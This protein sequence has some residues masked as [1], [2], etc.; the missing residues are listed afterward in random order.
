MRHTKYYSTAPT[1][2]AT[3]REPTPSPPRIPTRFFLDCVCSLTRFANT[4][5]P[6][7]TGHQGRV[8][9]IIRF[10][11]RSSNYKDIPQELRPRLPC[12]EPWFDPIT[13]RRVPRSASASLP[14]NG[15][16]APLIPPGY[17]KST[18]STSPWSWRIITEG[19]GLTGIHRVSQSYQAVISN[20]I[21]ESC[22]VRY[23]DLS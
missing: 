15:D 3:R 18:L 21:V 5:R 14:D 7:G 8:K 2:T 22:L 6:G 1:R 23:Q 11:R 17:G 12:H 16:S 20:P 4:P 13:L 9:L 19:K 10:V